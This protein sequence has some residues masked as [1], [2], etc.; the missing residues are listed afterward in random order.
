MPFVRMEVE[1]DCFTS[2]GYDVVTHELEL[3]F[4]S[5]HTYIY[6]GVEPITA[7][8]FSSSSSLGAYYHRLI[9]RRYKERKVE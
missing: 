1:S 3:S 8:E 4:M 6:S 7:L 5:G 9:K 2:I